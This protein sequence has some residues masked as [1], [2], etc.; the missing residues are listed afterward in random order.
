MS[1]AAEKPIVSLARCAGYGGQE[2][3]EA[4]ERLLR[5]LGGMSAFVRPG[6][7]VL[8]KPNLILPK[9]PSI[10]AQTHPEVICAV[11]QQVLD[12]GAKPIISDSPAWGTLRDCLEALGIY[13]RLLQ[14]GA[15]M[16]EM[17]EAQTVRIGRQKVAISRLALQ[18]DAIINLPK[19]KSHQQLGATF[20]V[21]NMFGCVVGKQ[22]AY[23]HFA[24]GHSF[25][26]FCGLLWGIYRHL[27][28][29]LNIVDAVVA[30]EGQGPISGSPKPLGLLVASTHPAACEQICC[31][32]IGADSR[33]L[34]ILQT[35]QKNGYPL[36]LDNP[37]QIVGDN[38]DLPVCRD[39]Q[40]AELIPLRFGFARICKSVAKQGILVVK[41]AALRM[42]R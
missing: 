32:A 40:M 41:N 1:G 12:C 20:A 35:A 19:F 5:P 28:P 39:F 11:A 9:P 21:K 33:T 26:A 38:V 6:W 17:K 14:M 34:P 25:D 4:V 10:P 18:A 2:V 36:F 31:R 42:F 37:I 30:M 13:E 3:R 23:W 24:R 8:I 15:E 22:K 29:I 16:I 7:R 27:N